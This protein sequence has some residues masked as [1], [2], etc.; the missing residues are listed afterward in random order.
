[1][2]TAHLGAAAAVRARWPST[3]FL[4]L[5][6]ASIAPDLVD[7]SFALVRACNP[8][9][10]YSHTVPAAAFIALVVGGAA[11]LGTRSRATAAAAAGLVLVH[12]P[13]DLV[14]GHKP[15]WPGGPALGLS[16]YQHPALDFLVE[17]PLTLGG[18]WMLR[19]GG[20]APRWAATGAA[21]IA[22]VAG[23]ATFD[24][25]YLSKPN[26]CAGG[27]RSVGHPPSSAGAMTVLP[28]HH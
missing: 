1:M 25:A 6:P 17:L 5:L 10:L 13:L 16:L 12:L 9:G 15:Y 14:T 11:Y 19:R 24:L 4:W 21:A 8:N 26:A 18:W 3:S 28:A 22:L 23:Q 7:L 27:Q 20:A 2:I